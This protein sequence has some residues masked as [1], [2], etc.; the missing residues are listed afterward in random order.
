VA[1]NTRERLIEA[2]RGLFAERG[3]HNATV[4]DIATRAQTNLASINY[5]FHSKDDLYR[6]VM[7]ASFR[8]RP[9][10]APAD[11]GESPAERLREFV[12]SMV[13][14]TGNPAS[15][16]DARE[17]QRK[18]LIAWE[19][20]SPTGIIEQADKAEARLQLD[21]A[22]TVIQPFLP[23]EAS[24]AAITVTALWLVGQCII[25]QSFGGPVR[26]GLP[27]IASGE[28]GSS[29]QLVEAILALA[30]RGLGA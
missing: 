13:P 5:H 9:D 19:V 8:Q 26:P 30:L 3:F 10:A 7:R 23:R 16:A 1:R 27:S 6:E 2:A 11:A 21:M 15:D 22:E 12:R 18:R 17:E 24:A 28:G 4:R 25:F 29:D 20:L 14:A